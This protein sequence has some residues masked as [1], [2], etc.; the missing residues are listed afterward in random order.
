MNTLPK[1][2][3]SFNLARKLHELNIQIP[4][5]DGYAIDHFTYFPPRIN[6]EYEASPGT[7]IRNIDNCESEY[8][9]ISIS[10]LTIPAPSL[11]DVEDYFREVFDIFI[12]IRRIGGS[13]FR[14]LYDI[15]YPIHGNYV[16][17]PGE[18]SNDY[19]DC[20][21][22]AIQAVLDDILPMVKKSIK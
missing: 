17:I 19:Y 11:H 6:S 1:K 10:N 9:S 16:S 14:Y 22:N 3:I 7:W 4:S 20:L 5:R 18:V 13:T 15:E 2:H 21:S 8:S 12:S